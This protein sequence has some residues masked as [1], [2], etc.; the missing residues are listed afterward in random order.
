MVWFNNNKHGYDDISA[1]RSC[2]KAGYYRACSKFSLYGDFP[3]GGDPSD[4]PSGRTRLRKFELSS[5]KVNTPVI[6]RF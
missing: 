5:P 3:V 2:V 4:R 6:I 1:K